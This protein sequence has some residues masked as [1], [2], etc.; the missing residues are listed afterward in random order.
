M[1]PT[2]S[3][4]ALATVSVEGLKIVMVIGGGGGGGG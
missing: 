1:L 4:A 3:Q 2:Y